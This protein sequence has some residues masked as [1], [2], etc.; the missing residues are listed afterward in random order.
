MFPL[1]ALMKATGATWRR[2]SQGTVQAEPGSGGTI[3]SSGSTTLTEVECDVAPRLADLY[4]NVT[5]SGLLKSMKRF[6]SIRC[7]PVVHDAPIEQRPLCNDA[8]DNDGKPLLH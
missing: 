6:D 4:L 3:D 7:T 1:E 8:T 2:S 5:R